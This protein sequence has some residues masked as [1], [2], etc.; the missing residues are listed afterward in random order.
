MSRSGAVNRKTK[1]TAIDLKLE[2]DGTGQSK[3]VTG[4]P[5]FDHMLELFTRH[6]LF[7]LTLEAD[8]DLAVDAHH[9]VEDIGICLGSALTQALGSKKGINRYG[10]CLMPMD[11]TLV[12]T[13]FDI[14]GRPGLFY[15]ID[16]P[17][18]IIG[19]YDTSLT[20]EFLQAFVSNAGLTLHSRLIR[21]GSGH[22]IVEAVFKGFARALKEA[23][24]LDSRVTGVPST[25]GMI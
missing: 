2:I 21:G 11:E 15:E 19:D 25:K 14:S 9:T 5:F 13:A 23:T 17:S 8:G 1:E 16:L 7:D 20:S 18:E 10:D 22:H 6:G 12:E 3:I 4:I 24:R